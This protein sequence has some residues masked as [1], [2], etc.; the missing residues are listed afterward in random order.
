MI[1]RSPVSLV[2]RLRG[3]RML[4]E[5]GISTGAIT[6]ET[7]QPHLEQTL[8][9]HPNTLDL[10]HEYDQAPALPVLVGGLYETDF[11]RCYLAT[12]TILD[13]HADAAPAALFATYA[14]EAYND[15]GAHFHVVKLFGWLKH[16]PAYDLLIEALHIKQP[17]FQK[18][19]AAAAI[20]LGELGDPRAI[21]DLKTCLETKIWDLKYAALMALEQFGD[22][23]GYEQVINDDDWL[24][25]EKAKAK[26]KI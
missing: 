3:I 19:R 14:E 24:I 22:T 20:A 25:R 8:H 6:F 4:G 13:H 1:A 26:L 16:A 10:V 12:K 9:D 18:S 11:G 23:S 7:I 21:P 17:Q 15:Y 5:A 2:F